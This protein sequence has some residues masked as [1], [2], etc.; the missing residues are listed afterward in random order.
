MSSRSEPSDPTTG[1]GSDIC[2]DEPNG[3]CPGPDCPSVEIE[4]NNTPATTDDLVQLK[5]THP[6]RRHKVPCR[7][8]ALGS[9][10]VDPILVL[11]NPDAR[12]RFPED[13]DTVK[14][15]I[16]PRNGSW[17]SFEISGEAPSCA[18]NDA[19]IEVYCHDELG[20]VAARKAV[21]VFWFDQCRMG[22]DNPGHYRYGDSFVPYGG[23]TV[24]YECQ[25][26]IRP[27]GVDCSAPQVS[28]LRIGIMQNADGGAI[29]EQVYDSP[30]I[31]WDPGI[32]SGTRCGAPQA[33]VLRTHVPTISND[34]RSFGGN[35]PNL[36]DH[37]GYGSRTVDPESVQPPVGCS[38]G[39]T[40]TSRDEPS[41][42]N[43]PRTY[44]ADGVD[45]G[46][47]K[48]AT[49]TYSIASMRIVVSFTTWTVVFDTDAN[50]CALRQRGWSLDVHWPRPGGRPQR[51]TVASSDQAP[52]VSPVV[53]PPFFN[54]L[55]AQEVVEPAT[56]AI[57]R[58]TKD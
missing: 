43:V 56:T 4:I 2:Y 10:S 29:Y 46:G 57:T 26:R 13:N 8:R 49:V 9:G 24:D 52:T 53:D 11:T 19:V 23:S 20:P 21:T 7:I 31:E 3:P 33:I 30:R 14:V 51:A 42:R 47:S 36:Y 45:S 41:I 35:V 16:V 6:V 44:D 15:L 22:I 5:C 37:P 1:P 48:V 27:D 17:V 54:E 39:R 38:G 55:L 50:F 32:A 25:A 40:A 18:R 28:G 58:F 34:G 12:L